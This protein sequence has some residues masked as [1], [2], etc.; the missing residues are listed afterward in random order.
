MRRQQEIRKIRTEAEN[1]INSTHQLVLGNLDTTIATTDYSVLGA[2]AGDIQ[3]ISLTFNGYINEIAHIL[4]HLSAGNMAVTFTKDVIYHGD[5]IPIKNALHKIRGSLNK[6]FEEINLLSDEVDKLSKQVEG[7]ASQIAANATDQANLINELTDTIYHITEQTTNNAKNAKKVSKSVNDIHNEAEVGGQ[8]MEQMMESIQKVQDSSE[9]ISGI[10][11]IISG[12]AAQTKLLALNASIEAARAGEA[13][14]GFCV[15][16]S[17]VGELAKKSADAVSRTTELIGHSIK[18]AKDSVQIANK[19]SESF[20]SINTSIERVS[21]LCS[22]I[23]EVSEV[24]AESLKNTSTIITEISGVVQNNAAYAQE[25]Y[26]VASNLMDLSSSLRR[27]M[28]KYRLR[29]QSNKAVAI[30][31]GF[32]TI[33]Q[34][35]LNNLFEKLKKSSETSEVD[36]ILEA[37]IKNQGDFECLYVIDG[38]G[39]QLS[40]TVLNPKIMI[41]QDENFKPAM[42]GDYYGDKKYFRQAILK[43]DTWYTSLE[44]ISTATGGLCRTLSCSYQGN[45]GQT[46]VLCIDLI[47]RF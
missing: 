7:G 9:D 30:N 8:Y 1:I 21:K 3:Q 46:Y 29:N 39:S 24:Q 33:D 13:G 47:S 15:V 19:T 17:E 18:T 16:A 40:H 34:A 26:A 43:K 4:S 38:S 37:A 12:L 35:F 45:G 23:A 11:T 32:D 42:P 20:Q 28:D 25:N 22:N 44:Y 27:V 2:L 14:R 10:I 6:S 31:N 5:F 41:E 36:K